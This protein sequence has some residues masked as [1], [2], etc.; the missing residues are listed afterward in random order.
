MKLSAYI[1]AENLTLGQF[2]ERVGCSIGWA[3][4]VVREIELPRWPF[5]LAAMRVTDGKV[6]PNDFIRDQ[7]KE[8]PRGHKGR[9]RRR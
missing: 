6:T 7:D 4:R 2:A 1:A 3:S 5:M 8:P 9:S